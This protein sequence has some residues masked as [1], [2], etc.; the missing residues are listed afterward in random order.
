MERNAFPERGAGW[1]S[2]RAMNSASEQ[3]HAQY[4][5]AVGKRRKAHYLER[6][7]RIAQGRFLGLSWN[8]AALRALNR[9]RQAENKRKP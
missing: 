3:E 9:V 8:W 2:S 7:R 5:A 6:F 4:A 1:T